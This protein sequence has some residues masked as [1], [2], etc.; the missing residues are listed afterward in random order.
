VTAH[1]IAL[2]GLLASAITSQ[3]AFEGK[4][5]PTEKKLPPVTWLRSP[6]LS[7]RITLGYDS[8]LADVYWIRAVQYYGDAKLST[9]DK[10]E[11]GLL[12]P[13]L[14]I[15][16]TLDPRF[17]IAYRFGAI[18]LSE[19]YPNGPGNPDQ[20]IAL[21][22][23]GIRAMPDR[24][25]YYHDAAF[26]NYWWRHD[27]KAASDWLLK[28]AKQP[29]APNWLAPTAASM[30]ARG[31]DRDSA[32]ALWSELAAASD[33]DWLRNAATR[34]LLQLDAEAVIEQLESA[35][36]RFFDDH[37]RFPADWN[38]L[39]SVMVLRGVPLDPTGAPYVIDS[40]SGVVDVAPDSPLYPLRRADPV[41]GLH[42]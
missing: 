13:L 36:Q 28:A 12:Y 19:G 5:R 2:V 33:Q 31:G 15:T 24:W 30:L 40:V 8:L 6:E 17:N 11:Y 14:D 21:L 16:T 18:L 20:A 34:A 32:R 7:R 26:V 22:Q 42:R 29:K 9:S 37:G 41:A 25:Q 3:V 23:K 10:K 4:L 38:E 39:V 1:W 35:A 27:Y